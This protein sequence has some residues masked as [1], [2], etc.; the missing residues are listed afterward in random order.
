MSDQQVPMAY[1]ART[2]AG[3]CTG[4]ILDQ[5][6]HEA[7]TARTVAGWIRRGD[8]VRYTT[9]EAA[10]IEFANMLQREQLA[11]GHELAPHELDRVR[12]G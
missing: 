8:V 3:K 2:R 1:L 11:R 7:S 9:A 6:G 4:V 10:R 5:I 12:G